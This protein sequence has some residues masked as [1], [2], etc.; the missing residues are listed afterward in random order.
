MIVYA[1]GLFGH[2]DGT[3]ASTLRDAGFDIISPDFRE[4][5]LLERV[6]ILESVTEN[7]D[8]I[9][10]IGSSYGGLTATIVVS[11][12]PHRFKGAVLCAP[13]LNVQ[14]APAPHPETLCI[15]P[16]IP[17]IILHG[18]QDDVVP[19]GVSRALAARSGPHVHLKE[20][21]DGHR[22]KDSLSMLVHAVER[23][24]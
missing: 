7:R 14:E 15:P 20:L 21:N 22:L 23:L 2:P 1:H 6:A 9:V 16:H 8:D 17:C 19:I 24:A 4:K 5:N 12:H 3:K 11:R 13:A 18:I 10:V